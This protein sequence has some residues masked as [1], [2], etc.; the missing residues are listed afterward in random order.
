MNDIVFVNP[1]DQAQHIS[2]RRDECAN[3][4]DSLQMVQAGGQT[5]INWQKPNLQRRLLA[6]ALEQ[7]RRL[8]RLPTENAER[9]RHDE[10]T[11]RRLRV[12]HV[13]TS[14]TWV[15]CRGGTPWPPV[16]QSCVYR[17]GRPRSA[18]PTVD[19]KNSVVNHRDSQCAPVGLRR[20]ISPRP[21]ACLLRPS[22]GRV[23]DPGA[24]R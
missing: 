3:V 20:R 10:H 6:E 18:A 12:S 1:S 21:L 13:H 8:H 23:P 17:H 11:H 5:W 4:L 7:T 9:R 14:H 16:N 15:N 2:D 19:P 24:A 22:L